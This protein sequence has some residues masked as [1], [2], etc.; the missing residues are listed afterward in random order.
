MSDKDTITAK[1]TARQKRLDRIREHIVLGDYGR[2][3]ED[4]RLLLEEVELADATR[5][6]SRL[7]WRSIEG[8][9]CPLCTGS[10]RRVYPNTTTWRGGG[11]AGQQLT[12]DVCDACWGSGDKERPGVDLWKLESR[13]HELEADS[14]ML[15]L[16]LDGAR[17]K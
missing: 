7:A 6:P 17:R 16:T 11:I 5:I 13:V 9:A 12:A 1:Q 15:R 2:H 8:D 3:E 14:R 4:I 10:G